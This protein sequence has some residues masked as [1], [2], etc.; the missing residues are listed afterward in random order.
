MGGAG[1]FRLAVASGPAPCP[2]A[3]KSQAELAQLG[4]LR[5]CR[6]QPVHK[7]PIGKPRTLAKAATCS[8]QMSQLQDRQKSG[9]CKS[10][11]C[12]WQKVNTKGCCRS[13]PCNENYAQHTELI[14]GLEIQIMCVFPRAWLNNETLRPHCN[15]RPGFQRGGRGGADTALKM[16]GNAFSRVLPNDNSVSG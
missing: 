8:T 2:W 11:G 13:S 12:R 1:S 5:T 4:R 9:G 3:S 16:M 14:P 6:K 15:V 7:S 10:L